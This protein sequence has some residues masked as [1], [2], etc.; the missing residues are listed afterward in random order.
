[1][2]CMNKRMKKRYGLKRRGQRSTYLTGTW[3]WLNLQYHRIVLL[4][5]CALVIFLPHSEIQNQSKAK[6]MGVERVP[7]FKII[8]LTFSRLKSLQRLMTSLERADYRHN[9][10]DLEFYID[11]G[12]PDVL[13]GFARE[14]N[15]THGRKRIF[16]RVI[17]GGLIQNVVES[18]V[19]QS[20]DEIAVFLE[21]DIEVATSFFLWIRYALLFIKTSL[22]SLN[23]SHLPYDQSFK[24]KTDKIYSKDSPVIGISLYTPRIIETV[25]P[26]NRILFDDQFGE[27]IFLYQIPCSW[28]AA[29]FAE[30]W[31]E[32]RD[33]MRH[34]LQKGDHV[35]VYGSTSNTWKDSWKK[36][37]IEYMWMNDKYLLFPNF[38]NQSSFSTNHLDPGQHI[39]EHDASHLPTDFTVPLIEEAKFTA[40]NLK[41]AHD[42]LD[43]SQTERPIINVFGEKV[44]TSMTSRWFDITDKARCK[45]QRSWGVILCSLT[46][47]E[48]FLY[49]LK[50][51]K[52]TVLLSSFDF[53]RKV[54]LLRIIRELLKSELLDKIIVMWQDQDHCPPDD[55]RVGERQ[56]LFLQSSRDSLNERF[57]PDVRIRTQAVLILDDDIL[58][59]KKDADNAFRVWLANKNLLVGFFPRWTRDILGLHYAFESENLDGSRGG[60]RIM[61]T[62]PMFVHKKYL[63][64][65]FC[66]ASR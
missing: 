65:Y 61:L 66:G 53:S 57:V 55:L 26:K 30:S 48:T 58:V 12:A 64:E 24:E 20:M 2:H 46:S 22:K 39:V 15:W 18:W 38:F 34:R 17:H 49:S 1:M 29:Y 35:E 47:R 42:L 63:Y 14:F 43:P 31:L 10:I 5:A 16:E 32:F 7:G 37:M 21:D 27:N 59:S 25:Y 40:E 36:F 23:T 52:Y 51:D 56:I 8:V 44:P 3:P 50:A 19:P 13:S 45:A 41:H 33:Y 11:A 9:L 6:E 60:Y 4:L 28:G 54:V 62:K